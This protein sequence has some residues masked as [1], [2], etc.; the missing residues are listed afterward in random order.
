MNYKGDVI[1]E[2]LEVDLNGYAKKNSFS[3]MY[4]NDPYQFFIDYTG[5]LSTIRH[6]LIHAKDPLAIAQYGTNEIGSTSGITFDLSLSG[7]DVYLTANV[8]SGSWDINLRRF[9]I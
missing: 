7:S 6:E 4:S 1:K 9:T 5:F 2:E 3:E 8:A